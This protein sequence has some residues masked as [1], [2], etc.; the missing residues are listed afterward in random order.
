MSFAGAALTLL[1]VTGVALVVFAVLTARRPTGE[2]PDRAGYFALW[3]VLHGGYD[4]ASG[5]VFLRGWLSV[6]WWLSRPLARRG[7]HPDVLTLSSVWLAC[8]IFLPAEAGG[9]WLLLACLLLVL[10][11]LFDSLDGC[12]AV[13]QD[14]VTAW[15]Y[16][17]DSVV[18]RVC[19][20]LFLT[21]L[22]LAGA[23]LLLAVGCGFACFLLEYVRARAG[24]AG[25]D[26]VGRITVGERP[27]RVILAAA[28][29]L[30]GGTFVHHQVLAALL[31]VAALTGLTVV[32]LG[33]LTVAVRRQLLAGGS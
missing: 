24:N 22:V 3:S 23:P 28:A 30:V 4:P 12:V 21:V 19:D 25:S 14:R 26:A 27:N 6:V 16:V 10:S 29:L 17:L 32:G 9:R 33:Q 8:T 1:A 5:S 31:A 13:L 20:A 11:G 7:V 15:G 18:D 2:I